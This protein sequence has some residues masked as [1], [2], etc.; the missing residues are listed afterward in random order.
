MNLSEHFTLEE[1]IRSQT[2]S[3]I[4]IDNTPDAEEIENG[5]LLCSLLLEP[6]RAILSKALGREVSMHIDSAFR[7]RALNRAVGGSETSVH[8]NFLA[9][10]V[11]P[12]L[13]SDVS[14]RM[15]FD[16][17]RKNF[18]LPYDQIIL[19]C[20]EWIHLGLPR[21]GHAPRREMKVAVGGPG[22]WQYEFVK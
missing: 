14:L 2:A 22:N 7:C 19:E 3:R 20:N 21:P 11:I 12:G 4:G 10:D 8:P 17:L 18:D 1:M 9:G 5:R 15:A 6:A 13:P 16:L